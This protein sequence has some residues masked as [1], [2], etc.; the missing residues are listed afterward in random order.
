MRVLWGKGLPVRPGSHYVGSDGGGCEDS[1]R[2]RDNI[3]FDDL[4]V[5]VCVPV[6]GHLY[7]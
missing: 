1:H 2:D 7:M 4:E 3:V 5:E 6:V